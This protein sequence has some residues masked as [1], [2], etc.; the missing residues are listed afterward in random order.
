MA[1]CLFA[2][3]AGWRLREWTFA[4]TAPV[5]FKGDIQNGLN[6]GGRVLGATDILPEKG[7]RI[8]ILP[9]L[10][11]W[12]ATYDKIYQE[13]AA[14]GQ[15]SLD[16][17]PLRLL[18][19]TLWTREVWA[20]EGKRDWA[21]RD[22]MAPPI[23]HFNAA[24]ALAAAGA[25]FLLVRH[26]V[27]RGQPYRPAWRAAYATWRGGFRDGWVLHK[28]WIVG[29]GAALLVW[30]NAA[31][32]IDA[33]AFPQWDIW[34]LPFFLAAA[35]AASCNAWLSAGVLLALGAML[36]GQEL[37][38]APIFPVWALLSPLPVRKPSKL[39]G[40]LRDPQAQ[41]A[42][43]RFRLPVNLFAFLRFLTGVA[44][45]LAAVTFPWLI[46][47]RAAAEWI[48]LS[49][50]GFV[51]FSL[52]R[53]LLI[54]PR[55]LR[56]PHM[57]RWEK[58][59]MGSLW[60]FALAIV[61]VGVIAATWYPTV[62]F[63]TRAIVATVGL[64]AMAITLLVIHPFK[65]LPYVLLGT[66]GFGVLLA[67]WQ[68]GGS[69]SWFHIGFLAPTD[70]YQALAMGPTANVPMLLQNEGWKLKEPIYSLHLFGKPLTFQ[71][72]L[73]LAY[74]VLLI[75][76][77]LM[78]PWHARRNSP[79]VLICLAAP[80]VLMFTLLPQ[81]HERYLVWAAVLTAAGALL[82]PGMFLAHLATVA[83]A[84]ACVGIQILYQNS[85]WWPA[86][87]KLFQSMVPGSA[88]ALVIL[89][90]VYLVACLTPA[91]TGPQK[92]G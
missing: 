25:M 40:F 70:H 59:L 69:W 19:M 13:G 14:S 38:A 67:G 34:L 22:E 64:A 87:I 37:I 88:W 18:V 78:L 77:V 10:K 44:F 91:R 85:R 92:P 84:F 12:V 56:A 31:A 73:R 58:W 68:M 39:S 24:I 49:A 57:P 15:Y 43:W 47:S 79:Q 63:S 53:W 45:G 11:S 80:W 71:L 20:Q 89:C 8:P 36:K 46:R 32:L 74:A 65:P 2:I 48:G 61:A 50:A 82:S 30:F 75:P 76:V 52:A 83:V 5:R 33:H 60:W 1:L 81:M 27:R 6:H 17:P 41:K 66:L 51:V 55:R 26:W 54:R 42:Q 29:V 62:S 90:G 23:L 21:Y 3:M 7:K 35:Y 9:V 28:G 86:A 4:Q 72:G 16:Y